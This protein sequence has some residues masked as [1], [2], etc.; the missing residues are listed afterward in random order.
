MRLTD[1]RILSASIVLAGLMILTGS[2]VSSCSSRYD[3]M[4]S[5]DGWG[6]RLNRATGDLIRFH[7]RTESYKEIA[8]TR[9]DTP[10][11]Q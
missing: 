8:K 7:R 1:L 10:D 4:P 2:C 6:Y 3:M 11:G 5:T 9:I